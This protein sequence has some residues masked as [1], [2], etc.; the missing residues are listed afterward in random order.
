[1]IEVRSS[2]IPDSSIVVFI[3]HTEEE[4]ITVNDEQK[5]QSEKKVF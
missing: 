2:Q 4:K 5:L 3:A 1:M